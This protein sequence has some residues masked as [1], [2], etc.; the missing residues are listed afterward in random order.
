MTWN[1]FSLPPH[2]H[3]EREHVLSQ[4]AITASWKNMQLNTQLNTH[5]KDSSG[6]W[7]QQI[8]VSIS[9][10]SKGEF[11][12]ATKKASFLL[13]TK[14]QSN[15]NKEHFLDGCGGSLLA[16]D[17]QPHAVVLSWSDG[18][19][20]IIQTPHHMQGDGILF[21]FWPS[22]P[23]LTD[24]SFHPCPTHSPHHTRLLQT[25]GSVFCLNQPEEATLFT[26][27]I[28]QLFLLFLTA[29]AAPRVWK[30]KPGRVLMRTD[31]SCRKIMIP[32]SH[33][34]AIKLVLPQLRF[35]VF[36]SEDIREARKLQI[37]SSLE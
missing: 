9:A 31:Y 32:Y 11:R 6:L 3:S 21:D 23:K 7:L 18:I 33:Y 26:K 12:R 36:R 13:L 37:H 35:L 5:G 17:P 14:Q 19:F 30:Q 10:S 20:P 29:P 4:M 16:Q 24:I 28:H 8:I 15:R 27:Y 1:S 22:R 2:G 34:Q 25:S